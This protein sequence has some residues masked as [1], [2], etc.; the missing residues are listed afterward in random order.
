MG[1]P[2]E[3]LAS[4]EAV[5]PSWVVPS[6]VDDAGAGSREGDGEPFDRVLKDRGDQ[7]TRAPER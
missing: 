6:G 2:Q 3:V 4:V 5:E 1:T 7:I